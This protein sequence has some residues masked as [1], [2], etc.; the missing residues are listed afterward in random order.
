VNFGVL[1]AA[2]DEDKPPQDI[3]PPLP[4]ALASEQIVEITLVV[5]MRPQF[6][7]LKFLLFQEEH[8]RVESMERLTAA[9]AGW[10]REKKHRGEKMP[11]ALLRRVRLAA[12]ERGVNAVMQAMR[13]DRRRLETSERSPSAESAPRYSRVDLTGVGA[14]VRALAFSGQFPMA[15]TCRRGSRR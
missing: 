14:L 4:W 1:P 12:G 9:V 7:G 10:R 11:D 2:L 5:S 8:M 3:F 6:R 13:I 15:V